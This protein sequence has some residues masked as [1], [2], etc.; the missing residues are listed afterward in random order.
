[1]FF[2]VINSLQWYNVSYG[3]WQHWSL[4][5]NV[6]IEKHI[7]W[8]LKHFYDIGLIGIQWPNGSSSTI[9]LSLF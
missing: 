1:M 6:L 4:E 8:S 9:L 3:C 2:K 7:V 5:C